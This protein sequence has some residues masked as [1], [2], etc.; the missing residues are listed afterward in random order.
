M[1]PVIVVAVLPFSLLLE[2]SGDAV[3]DIAATV[4]DTPGL[5]YAVGAR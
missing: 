5:L 1:V 3:A 2:V 4:S